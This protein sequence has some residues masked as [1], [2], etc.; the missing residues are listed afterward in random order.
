MFYGPE[1]IHSAGNC[2]WGHPH[3]PLAPTHPALSVG[4]M[5]LNRGPPSLRSGQS[6]RALT[7]GRPGL[8]A[9]IL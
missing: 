6:P 2:S 7:G 5:G 4:R 1:K 3:P 8:G 9:Q